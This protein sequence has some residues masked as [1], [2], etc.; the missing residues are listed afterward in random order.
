MFLNEME[1]KD[2]ILNIMN[3]DSQIHTSFLSTQIFSVYLS[4]Y[5]GFY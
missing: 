3:K 1:E 5:Y 4:D 2:S